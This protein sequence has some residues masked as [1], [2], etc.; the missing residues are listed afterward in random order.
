MRSVLLFLLSALNLV[1][2]LFSCSLASDAG[3][4]AVFVT[5][6][7]A[8]EGQQGE[9]IFL[10][11]R[12]R[13]VGRGVVLSISF[14]ATKTDRRSRRSSFNFSSCYEAGQSSLRSRRNQIPRVKRINSHQYRRRL[15]PQLACKYLQPH[16]PEHSSAPSLTFDKCI[17]HI[18]LS[19][20]KRILY[21]K[22]L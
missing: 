5:L 6:R 22:K 8:K 13:T 17:L 16:T 9:A 15:T 11:L 18:Y 20:H 12:S 7:P 3:A 21:Y 4:G 1:F 10:S 2:L 19:A 14:P